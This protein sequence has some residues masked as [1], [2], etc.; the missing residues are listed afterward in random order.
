VKVIFGEKLEKMKLEDKIRNIVA[1]YWLNENQYCGLSSFDIYQRI[2][3][4]SQNVTEEDVKRI[5]RMIN[6][7]GEIS[8]G[9]TKGIDRTFFRF[10]G[11]KFEEIVQPGPYEDVWACPKEKLL[12]KYDNSKIE[13]VGIYT[14]QLRLGDSQLTHRFFR[15]QV[16]DRYKGDPRYTVEEW[17]ASGN[18]G[19]K[20]KFFLDD[21]VPEADKI[22]IQSFGKGYTPDGEEVVA[23][24][25]IDL[26]Q[27]SIEHQNY[28]SSFEIRRKCSLDADYF[29]TDFEGDWSGRI[30][31]YKAFLQE[32]EE[33]NTICFLIN[34]P[35]LFRNTLPENAPR[36]LSRLTKPTRNEYLHFVHSLDKMISENINEE[37]FKGKVE[38]KK[39]IL[40]NENEYRI[41]DKNS[42]TLLEEYLNKKW[43]FSDNKPKEDMIETFREIRKIRQEPA[44]KVTNDVYDNCYFQKQQELMIRAYDA[45][46][47]LRLILKNHPKASSYKSPKWLNE[48]KIG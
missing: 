37:F 7:T 14:K 26:G 15:R 43:Q 21:S 48:G 35:L 17:G 3:E 38:T 16:L 47:T 28:W 33:T 27:L 20:D 10:N 8:I 46:R 22:S 23:V 25:L 31:T 40:I 29:R 34:E 13:E 11:S 24:I 45:V 36:E 1:N 30:S 19:I 42:I 41:E 5:L 6:K 9:L 39:K 12:K 4:E 2:R 44:H 18:I 32:L